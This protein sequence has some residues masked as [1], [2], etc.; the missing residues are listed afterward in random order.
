MLSSV[1]C[2]FDTDLEPTP[3]TDSRMFSGVSDCFF[4]P[5]PTPFS[6]VFSCFSTVLSDVFLLIF[7]LTPLLLP[8]VGFDALGVWGNWGG[9]DPLGD[10]GNW[11]DGL[12]LLEVGGVGV[13]DGERDRRYDILVTTAVLGAM[14]IGLWPLDI[15]VSPATSVT[16]VAASCEL[17]GAVVEE[18]D[19]TPGR[20]GGSASDRMAAGT[21]ECVVLL[22]LLLFIPN[23]LSAVILPSAVKTISATT[24]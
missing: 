8:L 4:N 6:A 7:T 19:M 18:G 22:F 10:W 17:G 24:G 16:S 11:G 14:S 23:T 20:A 5:T 1:D 12:I 9:F 21:L 2:S 3:H 13:S 15:G